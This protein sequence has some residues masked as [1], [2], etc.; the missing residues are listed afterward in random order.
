MAGKEEIVVLV[1]GDT[2]QNNQSLPLLIVQH[3]LSDRIG[4][5]KRSVF[6]VRFGTFGFDHNESGIN[7]LDF[8]R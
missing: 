7:A 6:V 4:L 1:V 2:V 5:G 3:W 8:G